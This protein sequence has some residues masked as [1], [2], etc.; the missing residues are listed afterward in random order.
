MIAFLPITRYLVNFTVAQGRPY[1][2]FERFL[3]EAL[4]E[5]P[6]ALDDLVTLF[7]VHRRVVVEGLVSLMQA[8]WIARQALPKTTMFATTPLGQSALRT[9]KLP[10]K[11]VSEDRV[12]YLVMEHLAG[13]IARSSAISF[14]PMT[15]LKRQR[16]WSLGVR[17]RAR[18][19]SS[20]LEMGK[21]RPF[22]RVNV[23]NDEYIR[24]IND[25]R[26]D[27]VPTYVLVDVDTKNSVL[28]AASV[29]K[30]WEALLAPELVEQVR[31]H[32]ELLRQQ[33]VVIDDTSPREW[34]RS[35]EPDAGSQGD[36]WTIPF[37]PSDLLIGLQDHIEALKDCL[38]EAKSIVVIACPSLDVATVGSLIPHIRAALARK[39]NVDVLWGLDPGGSPGKS[40][41]EALQLLQ[42]V[43]RE[44]QT[45]GGR[46][47]VAKES[48]KSNA[49]VL[50]SDRNGRYE[51]I[52]GS[53]DWL[54]GA[55][56]PARQSGSLRL[57]HPGPVSRWCYVLADMVA[58]DPK[59]ATSATLVG[60]RTAAAELEQVS[61]P[62]DTNGQTPETVQLRVV[63]DEQQRVAFNESVSRAS[64]H[65]VIGCD[66]WDTS[67]ADWVTAVFQRAADAGCRRLEFR[68]GA[69]SL[70]PRELDE[71]LII[72]G[73]Y[74]V[75]TEHRPDVCTN[76]AVA[77]EE[78][79]FLSSLSWLSRGSIALRPSGFEIGVRLEG[80]A[81]AQELLRRIDGK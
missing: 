46:I 40:F 72:L 34:L 61:P 79:V 17:I 3:L 58:A 70:G 39:V 47:L 44:P 76:Y 16:L 21:A 35:A 71:R 15:L 81:A 18:Q 63:Y 74:G 2:V 41:S 60:L 25:I 48:S 80:K 32:E 77:D 65:L 19:M 75:R 23:E 27:G 29:P 52:V 31:R 55:G 8:R 7:K 36:R 20:E 33:R 59:L 78:V 24:S 5:G 69:T 45:S 13:Q 49:R 56:E 10:E 68:Y 43:E 62:V 9:P 4:S 37:A 64:Q 6:M 73:K 22:L 12:T 57:S 50:F 1:S 14:R 30:D 67:G 66:K 28:K 54:G 51:A 11:Q 38:N 26:P 53:H 42:S